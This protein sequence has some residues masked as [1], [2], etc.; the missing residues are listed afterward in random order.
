MKTDTRFTLHACRSLVG[1]WPAFAAALLAGC[2]S[3]V[4]VLRQA[5]PNPMT[6]AAAFSVQPIRMDPLIV[7][8]KS[9]AEYRSSKA[10]DAVASW[11]ADKK[12]VNDEFLKSLMETA[13]DYAIEVTESSA[14]APF[15]IVPTIHAID[16][17]YYRIPAWNAVTKISVN[18][19]IMDKQGAV[20]DEFAVENSAPF[21]ALFAPGQHYYWKSSLSAHLSDGLN[22]LLA[23][24]A[25][26]LPTPLSVIAIQQL[27]GAAA[28]VPEDATAFPH[29]YHHW[30]VIF[31][32]GWTGGDGAKNIEWSRASWE[33]AQPF[34]R[35]AAYV[36]DLGE[37]GAER[38]RVAYGANYDRLLQLKRKYD[39]TNFFR[40]NQNI[41]PQA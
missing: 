37:E 35:Q 33:A 36:N 19:K 26:V 9:E 23:E 11:D 1:C 3:H 31:H 32:A 2:V 5:D 10:P 41:K 24:R 29:R 25:A 18:L 4:T 22:S 7:D 17:G 30:N 15:T 27:P 6:K 39:P 8:G 16:T 14:S 38:V 20:L 40:Q 13:Q 12:S 21:D 28:R 34:V